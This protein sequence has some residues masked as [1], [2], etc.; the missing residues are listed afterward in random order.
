MK[1]IQEIV[2]LVHIYSFIVINRYI[3]FNDQAVIQVEIL[4]IFD[5]LFKSFFF[6]I[7][8]KSRTIILI[9]WIFSDSHR[10]KMILHALISGF[11][12]KLNL[13]SNRTFRRFLNL[14]PRPEPF[15][16][17]N[18]CV[19]LLKNQRLQHLSCAEFTGENGASVHLNG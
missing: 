6:I 19:F 12:L 4:L 13:N 7:K 11:H 17:K 2:F 18:L 15:L 16:N 5:C 10:I 9:C 14:K 3:L 8:L 1:L